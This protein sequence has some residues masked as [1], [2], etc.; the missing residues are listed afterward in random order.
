MKIKK[1]TKKLTLNKK[2]VAHLNNG[3]LNAIQGGV[4]T[5][6]PQCPS[7]SVCLCPIETLKGPECFV[8][9]VTCWHNSCEV[10]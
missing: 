3:E 6:P 7:I 2:T 10:C 4:D 8:T 1:I 5:W 9:D